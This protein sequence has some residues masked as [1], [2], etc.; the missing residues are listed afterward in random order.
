MERATEQS[1]RQS[2]GEEDSPRNTEVS[3]RLRIIISWDHCP[4][5]GITGHFYGLLAI[6]G[7]LAIGSLLWITGNFCGSLGLLTL[8][9]DHWPISGDH[10]P[11]SGDHWLFLGITGLFRDHWP[12]LGTTGHFLGLLTISG[13]TDH[14][15]GSLAISKDCYF[16][17]SWL[18]LLLCRT[19][20]NFKRPEIVTSSFQRSSS[21]LSTSS[22]SNCNYWRRYRRGERSL[23]GRWK[24]PATNNS[25]KVFSQIS[26]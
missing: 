7:S 5:L 17:G 3:L 16:H 22:T 18:S 9:W 24:L 19:T 15:L 2:L 1:T 13:I 14:F 23:S 25:W 4:L 10:W 20:S 8:S 12:F 26:M 11:I 6:F 21:P